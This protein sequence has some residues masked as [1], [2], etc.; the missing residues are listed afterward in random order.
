ALWDVLH[1]QPI[2][3]FDERFQIEGQIRKLHEL[4]FAV[5]EV[6]LVPAGHG[7]ALRLKVAVAD[8]HYHAS[9]LR[10]LTGLVAGEGQATILLGDLRAYQGQLQQEARAPVPDSVAARRWATEILTPGMDR[11]HIAAAG[12]G[13]PIQAYCDLLEVRW[14]LSERAGRD[15]GDEVALEALARRAV[16][17]EAAAA[18]AIADAHTGQLPAISAAE[19]A[20]DHEDAHPFL[21]TDD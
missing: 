16:P 3:S 14:L 9:Q 12:V 4:G 21:P 13:R 8:R 19:L 15:V 1:A 18:M 2:I 10:D 7:D 20:M 11:A 5:D 17:S 6:A